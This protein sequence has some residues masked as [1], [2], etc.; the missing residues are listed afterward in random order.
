MQ[1]SSMSFE[2]ELAVYSILSAVL[3]DWLVR[4][5]RQDKISAMDILL[6]WARSSVQAEA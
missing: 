6:W 2:E 3:S 4:E 5:G 1:P